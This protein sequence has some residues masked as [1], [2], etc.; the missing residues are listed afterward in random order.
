MVGWFGR[1]FW[2]KVMPL[3]KILMGNSL[4]FNVFL[5]KPSLSQKMILVGPSLLISWTFNPYE[6]GASLN[7]N[8]E[9]VLTV[10]DTY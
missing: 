2:A 10:Y 7:L 4:T 8:L 3:G 5:L 6:I 1:W 9:I